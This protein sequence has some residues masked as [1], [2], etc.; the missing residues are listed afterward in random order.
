LQDPLHLLVGT[1][2]RVALDH[3]A[4]GPGGGHNG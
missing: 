1:R 2:G 3:D 4:L